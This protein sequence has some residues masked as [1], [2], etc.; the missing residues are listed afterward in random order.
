MQCEECDKWRLIFCKHKL[1]A[2]EVSE[3]HSILE[4]VSYTCGTT[5]DDLDLS[6][7]LTNVFVKD[8]TC[9]DNIERL[10]YSCSFEPFCVH[11]ASEDV[12]DA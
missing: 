2:Q 8:H 10:Y 1:N 6:G 4:D 11:C 3:L 7:R 9:E 5:F 12:T